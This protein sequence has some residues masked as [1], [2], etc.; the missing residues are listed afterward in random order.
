MKKL[1]VLLA[2]F[3][4]VSSHAFMPPREGSN[5]EQSVEF[6]ELY[7]NNIQTV[8]N[9]FSDD[10]LDRMEAFGH[11]SIIRQAADCVDLNNSFVSFYSRVID[12]ADQVADVKAQADAEME[13]EIQAAIERATAKRD[14]RVSEAQ[15]AMTPVLVNETN[16]VP[17]LEEEIETQDMTFNLQENFNF[18]D[19]NDQ[20]DDNIAS[21]FQNQ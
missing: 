16:E 3:T 21:D 20:Y 11:M 17:S 19:S 15:N 14:Q 4:T 13:Q 12:A 8:Q 1:S 5:C 9:S 2:I 7:T 18:L 10:Q 6:Y